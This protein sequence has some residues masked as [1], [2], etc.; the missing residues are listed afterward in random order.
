MIFEGV[1]FIST[2]HPTL[3]KPYSKETDNIL[4]FYRNGNPIYFEGIYN[5]L[6]SFFN[7]MK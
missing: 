7:N 5:F 1:S 2:Y 4:V 6:K 3:L